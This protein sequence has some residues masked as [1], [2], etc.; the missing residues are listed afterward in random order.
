MSDDPATATLDQIRERFETVT[1]IPLETLPLEPEQAAAFAALVMDI[2]SL[3]AAVEDA[4]RALERHMHW[5]T[6]H[7]SSI[8][9]CGG[10]LEP[11]PC[12]DSDVIT[13]AL[14]GGGEGG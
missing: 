2:P 14:N 6:E 12:P 9:L 5:F 13:R 11:V 7:G 4:A 3:V 1:A 8:K 10:C